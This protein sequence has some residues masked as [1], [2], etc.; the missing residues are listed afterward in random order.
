LLTTPRHTDYCLDWLYSG[1]GHP[2]LPIDG[3]SSVRALAW[4]VVTDHWSIVPLE[5]AL[6]GWFSLQRRGNGGLIESSRSTTSSF[7]LHESGLFVYIRGYFSHTA[8]SWSSSATLI[9]IGQH[10]LCP[11]LFVKYWQAYRSWR[12]SSVILYR[13]HLLT[14]WRLSTC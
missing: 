3:T 13:F 4:A 9:H 5:N 1:K 2:A 6:F 10:R 8:H 11:R 7:H 12:N 14:I